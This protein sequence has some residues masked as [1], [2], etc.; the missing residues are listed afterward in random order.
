MH[1]AVIP[2]V[3]SLS[4]DDIYEKMHELKNIKVKYNADHVILKLCTESS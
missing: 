1:C 4:Y 3:H 2:D